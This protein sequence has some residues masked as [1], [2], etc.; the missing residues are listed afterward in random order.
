MGSIESHDAFC[1][2]LTHRSGGVVVA[3]VEYRLAPEFQHPIPRN[4]CLD[5]LKGLLES[6]KEY[7]LDSNRVGVAGDSS[8]GTIAAQVAL[9]ARDQKIP[10]RFQMLLCPALDPSGE[11]SSYLENENAPGLFA[12]DMKWLW[13]RHLPSTYFSAGDDDDATITDAN[14]LRVA[15]LAGVAPAFIIAAEAD[16]L[17][18][19]AEVYSKRLQDQ[20]VLVSHQCYKGAIHAFCVYANTPL[21]LGDVALDDAVAV[22]QDAMLSEESVMLQ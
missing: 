11:T 16:V 19:E 21:S 20:G 4:D 13:R 8:G 6:S 17:R 22:I 5:A 9:Q 7:R 1:R 10:L 12:E 14:V 15:N 3:S 2:Q 18:D